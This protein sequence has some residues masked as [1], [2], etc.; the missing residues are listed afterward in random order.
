MSLPL[1]LGCL[2]V[3][4]A[5]LVAALPMR[6]QFAP[7]LALLIAA[8]GLILWIGLVHGWLL[9]AVGSFALLS[10]FRRPLIYF[11]RRALGRPAEGPPQ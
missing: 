7:G 11:T 10:M 5:A 1:L 8:P 6:R 4:V 2:W 3:V 9:A